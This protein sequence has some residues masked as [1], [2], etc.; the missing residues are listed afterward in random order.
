MLVGLT[1]EE[2]GVADEETSTVEEGSTEEDSVDETI[3]VEVAGSLDEAASEEDDSV[4]ET[5]R[6]EVAGSGKK[7]A[8]KRMTQWMKQTGLK[9]G[10]TRRGS[11][12]RG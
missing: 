3:S 5:N 1:T 4:D 10:L 2:L 9:G 12:R 11:L 7:Q 8:R 6:V